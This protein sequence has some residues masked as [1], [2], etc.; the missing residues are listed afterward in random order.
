MNVGPGMST[1]STIAVRIAH[2]VFQRRLAFSSSRTRSS[3]GWIIVDSIV[4][5]P[6]VLRL[7]ASSSSAAACDPREKAVK[8]IFGRKSI[9]I[10]IIENAFHRMHTA[11]YSISC[12][13]DSHHPCQALADFP[14]SE[15][16]TSEL[17]SHSDL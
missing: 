15:E 14:R 12:H 4:A 17:Q 2:S 1:A 7:M 3:H 9:Q 5:T 13:F 10:F 11:T 8:R 16:H 6:S